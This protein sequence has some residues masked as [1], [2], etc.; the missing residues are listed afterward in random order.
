MPSGVRQFVESADPS[1]AVQVR[2]TCMPELLARLG[3]ARISLLKMDVEG[4]EAVVFGQR[5]LSWLDCIDALVVEIH[6]DTS[7][8]SCRH[9]VSSACAGRFRVA[10]AGDLLFGVRR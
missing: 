6:E 8:G 4:A 7:Y 2:A 1:E 9:I 10:Y 3:G 5:D